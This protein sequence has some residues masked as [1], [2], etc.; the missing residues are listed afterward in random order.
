MKTMKKVAFASACGAAIGYGLS[1]KFT[2]GWWVLLAS[3]IGGIIG[4][5]AFDPRGFAKVV[6]EAVFAALVEMGVSIRSTLAEPWRQILPKAV[7]HSVDAILVT[8]AIGA[9]LAYGVM[10]LWLGSLAS[11]KLALMIAY[12]S[13]IVTGL[14]AAIALFMSSVWCKENRQQI[15]HQKSSN[16][17]GRVHPIRFFALTNPIVLPFTTMWLLVKALTFLV[18]CVPIV[19]KFSWIVTVKTCVLAHNNGRLASFAGASLGT[20]VGSI[21][22]HLIG[23]M[24]AGAIV[25]MCVHYIGGF[26]PRSYIDSLREQLHEKASA[27]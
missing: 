16:L 22:G 8:Q 6:S 14:L 4:W 23:A 13:P 2:S 25:G 1:A 26:F 20:V 17:L 11:L 18:R 12:G 7:R 19:V 27:L 3:L 24:I 9:V 21:Y 15:L 5:I 10:L